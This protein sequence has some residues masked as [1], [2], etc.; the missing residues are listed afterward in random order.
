MAPQGLLLATLE[1]PVR[2]ISEP[3]RRKRLSRLV[4]CC[5]CADSR[6]P[7]AGS[8]KPNFLQ[9]ELRQQKTMRSLGSLTLPLDDASLI[10]LAFGDSM[11]MP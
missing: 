1:R 2:R 11:L 7:A 8:F 6:Q 3:I 4:L 9:C 10:K 5:P